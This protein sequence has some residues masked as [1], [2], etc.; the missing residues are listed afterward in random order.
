MYLHPPKFVNYKARYFDPNS[1]PV[2]TS[3]LYNLV[4]DR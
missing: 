3:S 1:A 4:D 2:I